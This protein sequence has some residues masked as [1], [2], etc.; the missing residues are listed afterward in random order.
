M[1]GLPFV[2]AVH[3]RLKGQRTSPYLNHPSKVVLARTAREAIR[4]FN[5]RHRKYEAVFAMKV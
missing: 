4:R 3:Y 5:K 2:Y 1:F